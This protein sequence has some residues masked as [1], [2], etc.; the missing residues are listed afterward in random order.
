MSQVRSTLEYLD[1]K[2]MFIKRLTSTVTDLN[3]IETMWY[4]L[5]KRVSKVFPKIAEKLWSVVQKEW[6]EIDGNV[7]NKL[8]KSISERGNEILKNKWFHSAY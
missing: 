2:N 7:I 4:I 5:K 3:I 8:Y 6:Y 1:N